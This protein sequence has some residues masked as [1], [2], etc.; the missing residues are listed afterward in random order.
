[1]Q[2]K[3]TNVTIMIKDMDRSIL[4]Y[5]SLGFIVKNRWG[6]H[7]A[8]ITGSGITIGLHPTDDKILSTAPGHISIGFITDQFEE[9]KSFLQKSSIAST[10]RKEDG[11]EFL[12]FSDPDGTALYFYKA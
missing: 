8:Q 9:A 10:Q 12:H 5:Q 3:E 4:F 7:Y 11:G 2:I 1:M 6:N